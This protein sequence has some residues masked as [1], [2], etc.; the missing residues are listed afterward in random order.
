MPINQDTHYVIKNGIVEQPA[1]VKDGLELYY[2][3]KG[4]HN[5]DV[6]KGTLLDLS[7]NNRHGTLVN[8]AYEGV[9]GY[10]EN[11]T[12]G[13][14]LDDVDDKIVRPAI[15]NIQ[16]TSASRNRFNTITSEW[17][18]GTFSSISTN[19]ENTTRLRQVNTYTVEIG[20]PY[21]VS[22][23]VGYRIVANVNN[24]N[25]AWAQSTT[26]TSNNGIV[27]FVIKRAD[28]AAITLAEL[29][30]AKIQLEKN[31]VVTAYTPYIPL[32][33]MTYQMNG[34]ILSFEKDGT[35]KRTTKD[36]NG[37]EVVVSRKGINLVRNGI[38]EKTGKIAP[39]STYSSFSYT[40]VLSTKD[41][42]YVR[43]ELSPHEDGASRIFMQMPDGFS[44]R[45]WGEI[46]S[47]V[48]N[49]WYT[50]E[51][52]ITPRAESTSPYMTAVSLYLL[53]PNAELGQGK[54]FS[55][56]NVFAINLTEAYGAGNE[57]TLDYIKAHP[58]EFA[59]T[60]NPNDLIETIEIK[61]NLVGDL[62]NLQG[63]DF[64]QHEDGVITYTNEAE[65]GSVVRV[66]IDGI[67]DQ[68]LRF[69]R[70]EGE[71]VVITEHDQVDTDAI[72]KIEFQGNSVQLA[73]KYREVSGTSVTIAPELHDKNVAD[74]LVIGG[75]TTQ[76]TESSN[77][78]TD[79]LEMWLS[80]RNFS[81]SP[82]TTVWKDLTGVNNGTASGFAF[83]SA[84]GSDGNGGVVFDGVDDK[85]ETLV[86]EYPKDYCTMSVWFKADNTMSNQSLMSQRNISTHARGIILSNDTIAF[87]SRNDA[88]SWM[89]TATTFTD[90]TSW[91]NIC[92][93]QSRSILK[94]YVDGMFKSSFEMSGFLTN[95]QQNIVI[96]KY[97]EAEFYFKGGISSAIVYNRALSDAE[98]LQNYN[99]GLAIPIPNIAMPQEVKHV[100]S[101][102]KVLVH[103]KNLFGD[104]PHSTKY[105]TVVWSDNSFTVNGLW[106]VSYKYDLKPNTNYIISG[107]RTGTISSTVSVWGADRGYDSINAVGGTTGGI[108]LPFNTGNRNSVY[109]AFYSGNSSSGTSTF[110][111][112]QLEEGSTA[113][114][115]EPFKG[116][117]E[118]TIPVTL[119]SIG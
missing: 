77:V 44:N 110:T 46:Y 8:F 86:K 89:Q 104:R 36:A 61:N 24:A 23:D 2:D 16:Y 4:K 103:G 74:K 63:N 106:Y 14:L 57:P 55:T 7:G 75:N 99:A 20:V 15:P 22:V 6:H 107:T 33:I 9:S 118:A 10:Q 69:R 113:T 87:W 37:N 108:S 51:G 26:F 42:I 59:W 102:S 71:Q 111:N 109:I 100:T 97:N 43:G 112:I 116:Y 54:S 70:A 12:G 117:Q 72:K 73:D 81:N 52:V 65:E 66:D 28:E 64:E 78:V 1:V 13:I 80:G 82:A 29:A 17:E 67:S 40:A 31:S 105:G 27:R 76:Y 88:G 11:G 18:I 101:G 41:I 48:K 114:A 83:T 93:V 38:V 115:Y 49:Q 85:V 56:R 19:V 50:L 39:N 84:S 68:P 119:K 34:N 98:V 5:T 95:Y 45:S 58:E 3:A 94:I 21:A 32:P 53:Y 79:G 92:G 47:P 96:G 35:V 25:S 62:E 90:K 30:S 91:H 60:P